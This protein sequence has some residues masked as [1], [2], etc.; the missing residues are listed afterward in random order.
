VVFDRIRETVGKVKGSS[1]KD[2]L[3]RAI[4]ETLSRTV[5]TAT[6]VLAAC[7]CLIVL[8]RDTVLAS[9]GMIML[10]GILIGTYSSIYVATPVFM[11]FR[12]RFGKPEHAT[13]PARRGKTAEAS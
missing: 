12:L 11:W 9:Y 2:V 3:N 4:N 7:I 5:L 10:S 6:C 1:L 8:G 13:E